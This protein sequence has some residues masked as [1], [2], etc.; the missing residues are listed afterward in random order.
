MSWN[1]WIVGLLLLIVV[2]LLSVGGELAE[3]CL[4]H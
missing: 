2:L 1:D 3:P 4:A